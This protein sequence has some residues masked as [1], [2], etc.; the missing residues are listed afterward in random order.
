M[1]ENKIYIISKCI[2][3][4]C[5]FDPVSYSIDTFAFEHLGDTAGAVSSWAELNYHISIQKQQLLTSTIPNPQD[6]KP[7]TIFI[8]QVLYG[9]S[10]EKAVIEV[11]E[12][13]YLKYSCN[14]S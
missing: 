1:A 8:H 4:I 7:D 3:L 10:R 2:D 11:Q 14:L 9:W 6:A 12:H 5:S 13:K